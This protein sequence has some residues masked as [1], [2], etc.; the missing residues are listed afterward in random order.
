MNPKPLASSL[1]FGLA[2]LCG[3]LAS[4]QSV[5]GE[6]Q[7]TTAHEAFGAA[8]VSLG[9]VNGDG[10]PD[11]AV[12]APRHVLLSTGAG[13]VHVYSGA[14]LTSLWSAAGSF[15]KDHFGFALANVGDL[16][17]DGAS[18]LL[19][20]A[21]QLSPGGHLTVGPAGYAEVRSGAGGA[22]IHH[23]NGTWSEEQF[24]HAVAGLGDLNGDGVGDFAVGSSQG[25]NGGSGTGA[26]RVC[27]GSDAAELFTL[28]GFNGGSQFGR[29]VAS[30]GDIDGDGLAEILVGAPGHTFNTGRVHLYSGTG[31]APLWTWLGPSQQARFGSALA[32]PGDLDLDGVPDIAIGAPSAHGPVNYTGSLSVY[33][34]A[35]K[36]LIFAVFG[37]ATSSYFGATV[38]GLGDITNDGRPDLLVGAHASVYQGTYSGHASVLSGHQGQELGRVYGK[39]L[40]YLGSSVALLGDLTGDGSPEFS[41]GGLDGDFAQRGMLR[42]FSTALPMPPSSYCTGKVNS[43]GCTPVLASSGTPTLS[44][45]DDFVVTA[46]LVLNNKLGLV[47]WSESAGVQ[48]AFNATL[49]LGAPIVRTTAV[50][51][52]GSAGGDDCSGTIAF[53]FS[54]AYMTQQGLTASDVLHAQVWYRDPALP[55]QQAGFSQA[56][57]ATLAP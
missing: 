35:T 27:S 13:Q 52:G 15:D 37:P 28:N 23:L 38:V 36:A 1:T 16:D 50:G 39:H 8:A 6:F 30:A 4:A 32:G 25:G 44:G 18:D 56:L 34:G 20:G 19:I 5:V 33:S 9:D 54:H 53:H 42:I 26:V 49:C 2:L 24:G 29:T 43:Q 12:S 10:V 22:L 3:E 45:A 7:G 51:S 21:P 17:G 11:F 47:I 48:P 31:G 40:E 57:A 46:T 41:A 55:T 14:S